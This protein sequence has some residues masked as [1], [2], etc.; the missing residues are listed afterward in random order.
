MS[1]E[2][3]FFFKLVERFFLLLKVY[4]EMLVGVGG[5]MFSCAARTNRGLPEEC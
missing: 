2:G 4:E 3:M 5:G 1:V